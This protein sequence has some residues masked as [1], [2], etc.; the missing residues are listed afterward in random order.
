[1]P[2]PGSGAKPSVCLSVRS[3]SS[4]SKAKCSKSTHASLLA[5]LVV[6]G[7]SEFL[8]GPLF[9]CVHEQDVLEGLD[10]A[11]VVGFLLGSLSERNAGCAGG[12]GNG[13]IICST[14]YCPCPAAATKKA[15]ASG[16]INSRIIRATECGPYPAA[17]TEKA[18]AGGVA[19]GSTVV[20]FWLGHRLGFSRLLLDL[21]LLDHRF[22]S[23]STLRL[24]LLLLALGADCAPIIIDRVYIGLGRL[25]RLLHPRLFYGSRDTLL[26]LLILLSRCVSLL[27]LIL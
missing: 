7:Q 18:T 8:T 21:G 22:L 3:E 19:S 26:V 11:R 10:L 15:T 6:V 12:V 25:Y 14:K 9:V 17:A 2:V 16:I 24:L 20:F 1:M 27:S 23:G 4:P 13:R 5:T